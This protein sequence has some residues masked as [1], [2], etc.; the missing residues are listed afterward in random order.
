MYL[1]RTTVTVTR[2][3][4]DGYAL[5][6]KTFDDLARALTSVLGAVFAKPRAEVKLSLDLRDL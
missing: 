1:S 2:T 4:I 6:L 5:P 3:T